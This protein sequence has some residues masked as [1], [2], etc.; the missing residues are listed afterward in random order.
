[1]PITPAAKLDDG[2]LDLILV[3]DFPAA[4]FG[5]VLAELQDL[6]N[7]DN[8]FV[9]YRQLAAFRLEGDRELPVNLDG[10]RY[11]WKEIDFQCLPGALRAVL[12]QACPLVS[13][14]QP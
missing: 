4:E 6:R 7:P 3:R 12:P 10:E 14:A 13:K 8:R 2:L 9:Y 11:H 1:M 5:R